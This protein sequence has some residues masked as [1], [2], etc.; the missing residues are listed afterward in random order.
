MLRRHG[1]R[2]RCYGFTDNAIK[3]FF[4]NGQR[5][6]KGWG[7]TLISETLQAVWN[8]HLGGP[9]ILSPSLGVEYTDVRQNAFSE[10]G[11]MPR[12]FNRG[13]YRNISL[14]VGVSLQRMVA[15]LNGILWSNT[16]SLS[17]IPDGYRHQPEGRAALPGYSWN[18][19]GSR[20]V[21]NAVR[22]GLFSRLIL[23]SPWNIYCSYQ[24]EARSD[25]GQQ[26]CSIGLGYAFRHFPN[27]LPARSGRKGNNSVK[28]NR[29]ETFPPIPKLDAC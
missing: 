24:M 2:N 19:A 12:R 16:V 11:S 18:V 14:P 9:V 26:S 6:N 23:N 7:N 5:S 10:T 20:A 1:Q 21:R 27:P 4:S 15:L 22:A 17:Y 28:K 29:R 25:A 3:T 8:I 13:R